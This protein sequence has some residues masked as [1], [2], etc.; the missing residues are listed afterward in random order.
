MVH[1]CA[2]RVDVITHCAICTIDRVAAFVKEFID[3]G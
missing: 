1:T 3:P 2:V